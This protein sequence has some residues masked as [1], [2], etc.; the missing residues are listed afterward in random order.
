MKCVFALLG[1]IVAV[2][3]IGPSMALCDDGTGVALLREGRAFVPLRLVAEWMGAEVVF[4][5]GTITATR[6]TSV[7]VL[8]A[9]R[10]QASIDGRIRALDAPPF[11]AGAVTYVPLRTF[12]DA[13]GAEVD[14]DAARRTVTVRDNGRAAEYFALEYRPGWLP[15][16]G[17]WFSI[18]Y[19]A[20][21]SVVERERSTSGPGYDGVSFTSDDGSLELYVF[22]PQW[23]GDSRW[24]RMRTGERQTARSRT[25]D[26]TRTRT[27]T[28]YA[29]PGEAY[30]RRIEEITDGESN[31]YHCF[32][33]RFTASMDATQRESIYA[34]FKNSLEQY[35]D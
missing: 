14:Y 5:S 25:A 28:T 18:Q 9:G 22:S 23:R 29:G 24:A 4:R 2:S 35:A 15:Y 20:H 1:L 12:A 7:L 31:T 10:K 16:V 11:T 30:M 8:A 17:A 6:G 26:G 3:V 33:I 32:G 19:P 21:L 13:F 27:V 34:R